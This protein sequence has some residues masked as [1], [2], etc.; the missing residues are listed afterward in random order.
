[1]NIQFLKNKFPLYLKNHQIACSQPKLLDFIRFF[2][3]Y[4][5]KAYVPDYRSTWYNL[6]E[7]LEPY[8]AQR[9]SKNERRFLISCYCFS[10][11]L[12]ATQLLR[13]R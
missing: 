12:H 2:Y 6:A 1:M 7:V 9:I 13:L 11:K 3:G 4:L 10:V 5:S 8:H